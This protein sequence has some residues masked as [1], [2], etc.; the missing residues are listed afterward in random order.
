MDNEL[1]VYTASYVTMRLAIVLTF[2]YG[3]YVALRPA[4]ASPE[5]SRRTAHAV[6]RADLVADDRC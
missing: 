6:R 1:F 4:T 2:A 5:P 3:L